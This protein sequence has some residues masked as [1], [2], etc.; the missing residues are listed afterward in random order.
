M[1]LTLFGMIKRQRGKQ[2]LIRLDT[3]LEVETTAA[4]FKF[5]DRVQVAMDWQA[6][7]VRKVYPE[8]V[9]VPEDPDTD[10]WEPTESHDH[11]A[12]GVDVNVKK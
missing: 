5:G 7:R 9:E 3:G 1:A 10:I 11:T 4:G 8:K 6:G 2:L 12:W